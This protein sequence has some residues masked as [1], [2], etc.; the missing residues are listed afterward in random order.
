MGLRIDIARVAIKEGWGVSAIRMRVSR[1]P[2]DCIGRTY[3]CHAR[4]DG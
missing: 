2:M 4:E 1:R 3:D